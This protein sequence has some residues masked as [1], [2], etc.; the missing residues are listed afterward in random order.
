MKLSMK[1]KTFLRIIFGGIA[2]SAANII[3]E[4]FEKGEMN[5]TIR[6][7]VRRQLKEEKEAQTE[8]EEEET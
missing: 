8:N 4:L 6:E 2:I 7:E 3:M 1:T 5:E